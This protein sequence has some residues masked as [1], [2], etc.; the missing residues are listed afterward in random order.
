LLVSLD[1][2]IVGDSHSINPYVS[3]IDWYCL[4]H[5]N[6]SPIAAYNPSQIRSMCV[7]Y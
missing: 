2:I 1:G 7:P 5:S 4:L 3:S 6:L